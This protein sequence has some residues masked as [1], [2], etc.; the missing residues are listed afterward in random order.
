MVGSG[1]C[2]QL[3]SPQTCWKNS[4]DASCSWKHQWTP[5]GLLQQIPF[6]SLSRT[7]IRLV[8][9]WTWHHHRLHCFSHPVCPGNDHIGQIC[10]TWVPGP[11]IKIG[12]LPITS[13]S[14]HGRR[15]GYN[16][17]SVWCELD[18]E[19][20]C[21]VDD[22][23]EGCPS[24]H[25]NRN[26]SLLLKKG[27]VIQK[28]RFSIEDIQIPTITENPVKSLGKTFDTTPVGTV[29][30]GWKRLT[31]LAS[32][33]GS[34]RGYTSMVYYQGSSGHCRSTNSR[35]LLSPTGEGSQLV[36]AKM[37]GTT[38]KHQQHCS[39]C[40]KLRLPLKSIEEEFKVLRAREVL[41][42]RES[43]GCRNKSGIENGR[44]WRAEGAVEAWAAVG[45]VEAKQRWKMR[46]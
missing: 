25:Q 20:V 35:F 17:V 10:R 33:G 40:C 31:G 21:E 12:D 42:Y 45:A 14:L 30:N 32:L 26:R 28:F 41:Q 4:A 24:S 3:N 18:S 2:L 5:Y 38:E 11:E 44:K 16:R 29:S 43:S 27:K 37:A 36:P 34:K 6:E 19:G 23:L 22:V 39:V 9:A 7:N 46:G 1:K 13:T 8:Q 15:H